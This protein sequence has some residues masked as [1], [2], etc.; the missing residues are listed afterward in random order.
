MI[1]AS[2]YPFLEVFWTL[3]V[4]FA[5]VIWIWILFVV[6]ADIFR[7]H[8]ISGWLKVLWI[9]VIILIPYFGVF[10]YLIAEHEGMTERTIEAQKSTQS[11]MDQYVRSVAAKG[12]PTEQIS[13]AKQLLDSGTITQ[14]EFDQIK[15]TALSGA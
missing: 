1:L 11:Q 10:I 15:Q 9:V 2:S 4:F 13:K 14:A 6:L 8:D 12:D 5:F 7:R 3:L